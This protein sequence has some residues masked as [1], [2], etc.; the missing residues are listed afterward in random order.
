MI[1][2]APLLAMHTKNQY[3]RQAA[4]T[5]A[6]FHFHDKESTF[7]SIEIKC[8]PFFFPPVALL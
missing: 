6:V 4:D 7:L 8:N 3:A 1:S 2:Q 5:Q